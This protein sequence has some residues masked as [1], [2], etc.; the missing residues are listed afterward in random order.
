M[1]YKREQV[2][3]EQH[4]RRLQGSVARYQAEKKKGKEEKN[5][6]QEALKAKND[7]LR[8]Q[9]AAAKNGQMKDFRKPYEEMNKADKADE[10]KNKDKDKGAWQEKGGRKKGGA[11][12][13][14][15]SGKGRGKGKG[16]KGGGR[17]GKGGKRR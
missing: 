13:G 12:A 5:T 9:L 14:A 15:N 10:D 8:Q 7:Q 1:I 3:L 11:D 17:K 2:A 6:D 16:G 4:A